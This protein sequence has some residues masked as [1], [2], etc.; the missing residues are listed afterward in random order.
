M[1]G[2]YS[3]AIINRRAKQ[4]KIAADP[5]LVSPSSTSSLAFFF[6]GGP[7]ADDA[8]G[9]MQHTSEIESG[10]RSVT[11]ENDLDEFL[12]TAQLAGTDF[13]AGKHPTLAAPRLS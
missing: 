12:S 2:S 13:A 9:V 7:P 8:L 1:D 4:A 10:L 5:T 3:R 11:Q 6:G